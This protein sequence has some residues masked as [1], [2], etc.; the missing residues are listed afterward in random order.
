MKKGNVKRI[1]SRGEALLNNIRN[2]KAKVELA[3][4]NPGVDFGHDYE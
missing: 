4:G 1:N 3:R 2:K